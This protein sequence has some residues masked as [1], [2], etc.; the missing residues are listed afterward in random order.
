MSLMILLI[1]VILIA[2]FGLIFG[3]YKKNKK[4]VFVSL[5]ICVLLTSFILF[6]IFIL[7]PRM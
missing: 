5:G 7:I 4:V 6:L 3:V 1:I 2:V